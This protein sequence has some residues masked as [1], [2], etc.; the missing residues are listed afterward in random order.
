MPAPTCYLDR[1]ALVPPPPR[2]SG[3]GHDSHTRRRA[4]K[5]KRPNEKPARISSVRFLVSAGLARQYIL[6]ALP[7]DSPEGYDLLRLTDPELPPSS[8][9][10]ETVPSPGEVARQ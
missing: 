1:S 2:R 7:E 5:R 4:S 10:R 9:L 3:P 8:P 6:R